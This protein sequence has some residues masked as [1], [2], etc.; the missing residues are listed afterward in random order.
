MSRSFVDDLGDLVL[1]STGQ[2]AAAGLRTQVFE[3]LEPSGIPDESYLPTYFVAGIQQ[4]AARQPRDWTEVP[5]G[6]IGLSWILRDLVPLIPGA[7]F[8]EQPGRDE[9]VVPALGLALAV[10][11]SRTQDRWAVLETNVAAA[12][13]EAGPAG[14]RSFGT[15]GPTA[16][17]LEQWAH[18]P[19]LRIS[20]EDESIAI[21]D[22]RY[23][24]PLAK[25]AADPTTVKR[26]AILA[27]LD[28]LVTLGL[29]REG[30][31]GLR[32]IDRVLAQLPGDPRDVPADTRAW[33]ARV[34]ALRASALGSGPVSLGRARELAH[35]LLKG[36]R[37]PAVDLVETTVA[38]WWQFASTVLGAPPR[39]Y[40]YVHPDTG[41]L[42]WSS[43][44]R[45]AEQLA[46]Q[47]SLEQR[48]MPE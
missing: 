26:P 40:L 20:L 17:Q 6:E 14:L 18:D 41:A 11:T 34:Q 32:R 37:R 10:E 3:A 21:T 5:D 4:L 15:L 12:A 25:L 2:P 43:V 1:A 13:H 33:A 36:L 24:E 7:V 44:A 31:A 30:A 8:R 16:A 35:Q 47:G 29:W 38:P 28:D 22:D 39:E 48:L 46:E 27:A 19:D 42:R 9:V 45:T 23:L